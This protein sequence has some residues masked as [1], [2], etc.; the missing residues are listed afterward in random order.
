MDDLDLNLYPK[1]MTFISVAFIV[2]ALPLALPRWN[3]KMNLF[4]ITDP[5]C[6]TPFTKKKQKTVVLVNLHFLEPNFLHYFHLSLCLMHFGPPHLC[7]LGHCS[8]W[9]KKPCTADW[10]SFPPSVRA[11]ILFL[12]LRTQ[13][14]S[15]GL[16]FSA[17][18]KRRRFH[19]LPLGDTF[20][21]THN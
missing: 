15:G 18:G 17:N 19:F 3:F 9:L 12:A 1:A 20:D 7:W 13:A 5:Q 11:C 6:L 8:V 10:V 4:Q 16:S 21:W 2:V 14:E